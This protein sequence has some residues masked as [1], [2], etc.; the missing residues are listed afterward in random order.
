MDAKSW[1]LPIAMLGSLAVSA[2]WVYFSPSLN[3][4][5]RTADHS[6]IDNGFVLYDGG[7][8][9]DD[10]FFRLGTQS[11]YNHF[12]NPDFEI[13]SAVSTVGYAWQEGIRTIKRYPVVGTGPDC[14]WYMQLRRSMM[15]TANFNGVDRPYN[16]FLYVAASRGIPS[17]VLYVVL[18]IVC[19]LRGIKR[20]K[21]TNDWT[22]LS[23]IFAV[24]GFAA[25][26]VVGISVLTVSPLMWMMLGILI[27]EPIADKITVPKAE[28]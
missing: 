7:V 26:S 22:F 14:F 8:I 27:A 18:L 15:L 12:V 19:L 4:I 28:A 10:G 1:V 6:Q 2:V 25:A 21:E 16:D 5:Y 13:E 3:G 24:I 11:P 20:R 9:W 17:L 23:A